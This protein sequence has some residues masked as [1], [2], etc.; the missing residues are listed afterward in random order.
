MD[1]LHHWAN[2]LTNVKKHIQSVVEKRNNDGDTRVS[3]I[4]F[5][6]HE[7]SDCNSDYSSCTMKTGCDWHPNVVVH[8]KMAETLASA[9]TKKVEENKIS[10]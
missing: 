6:Q 10:W 3:F 4:E 7:L 1:I 9:I 5:D 2:D 8:K